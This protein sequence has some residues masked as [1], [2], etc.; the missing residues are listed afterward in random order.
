MV[1][2]SNHL[3]GK[4]AGIHG[5]LPPLIYFDK[6]SMSGVLLPKPTP[7]ENTHASSPLG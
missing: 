7:V 3:S 2:L 4:T 1:S 5:Y 6:L